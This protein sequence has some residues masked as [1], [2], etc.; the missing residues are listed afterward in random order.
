MFSN[1]SVKIQASFVGMASGA[2]PVPL[3][4]WSLTHDSNSAHVQP[5][6]CPS[7]AP[8]GYQ[9][10]DLSMPLTNIP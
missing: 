8:C 1:Q 6:G 4:R 5:S 7:I 9:S 3:S 10:S 2:T